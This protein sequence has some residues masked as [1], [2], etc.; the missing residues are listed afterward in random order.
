M[1]DEELI[2]F[3]ALAAGM[4]LKQWDFDG[5]RLWQ[6]VGMHD[7]DIATWSP[8]DNDG[9]RYR[10]AIKLH[11]FS[12]NRRALDTWVSSYM[13]QAELPYE[14]AFALAIVRTAAEIGKAH[15][16]TTETQGVLNE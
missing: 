4:N 7:D 5:R 6:Y 16:Q 2:K 10:L 13:L 8:L 9:D 12:A 11:L 3:A 15:Q 1:S 14:Q